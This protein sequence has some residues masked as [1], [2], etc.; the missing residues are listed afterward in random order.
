M[1][2]VEGRN[3]FD[4]DMWM[5]R[6]YGVPSR[7]DETAD[8]QQ[9]YIND[10]AAPQLRKD[11][12]LDAENISD[13]YSVPFYN[14]EAMQ[15]EKDRRQMIRYRN[16]ALSS[17]ANHRYSIGRIHS[18]KFLIVFESLMKV[19]QTTTGVRFGRRRAVSATRLS[20]LTFDKEFGKMLD[21]DRQN[22]ITLK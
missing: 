14:K 16:K 4:Y 11:M 18:Y 13:V 6:L 2:P 10:G 8:K 17:K 7:H 9:E 12:K 15:I 22:T 5:N 19:R 20:H 21:T 3:F 1:G